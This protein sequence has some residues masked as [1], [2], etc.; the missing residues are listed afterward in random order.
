VLLVAALGIFCI[1]FPLA[2]KMGINLVGALGFYVLICVICSIICIPLLY[3]ITGFYAK[4]PLL[5]FM[6]ACLP[7]QLIALGTQSSIA[8]LPSMVVAAEEKL[9]IPPPIANTVLPLAVSIFKIGAAVSSVLY[10]YFAVYIYHIELS[11]T[12]VLIVFIVSLVTAIGGAGLPSGASFWAP[13]V[14]IFMAVGLPVEI[15]PVLFA[16]DI[17]PD[18]TLTTVSVTADMAAVTIVAK[19]SEN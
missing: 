5:K 2:V 18:M 15:I 17:I 10:V 13:I 4:T 16:V 8:T 19:K 6:S 11:L 3:L 14:T 9:D 12:Q 1:V 7:P